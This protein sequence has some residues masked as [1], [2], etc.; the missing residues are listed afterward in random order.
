MLRLNSDLGEGFG[1][2]KMGFEE[3][4]MPLIDMANIACGFHAGDP[5]T[6]Q[7][8][9]Q[10][11]ITN[12]VTIGAHPSYPD[13]VGFGRRSLT[14]KSDEIEA[15][16]IYQ[17][18]ALR[19]LAKANGGDI[20]YIKPHGALYN[21][22]MKNNTIFEAIINA[23]SKYDA[24]LKLMILS[25]LKNDYFK[26]L[27]SKKGVSLL[28]EVFADR[29][30]TDE[31]YLVPRGEQGAL[32]H[33][34]N[35]VVERLKNLQNGGFL[36]SAY[37]KKLPLQADSICVHGDNKEALNLVQHLREYLNSGV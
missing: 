7:K 20:E 13:L 26:N 17:C 24:N 30:Y 4:I 16:I 21:D 11:A 6:L 36:Y 1:I 8:T 9:L 5:L 22:M 27:A 2:Y 3:D 29:G 25:S 18:G 10:L 28:F 23:I 33:S 32:L 15:F 12:N 37:G 34:A 14:C 19:A 31:G 35:K